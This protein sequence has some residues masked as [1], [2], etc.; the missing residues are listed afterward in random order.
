MQALSKIHYVEVIST[1]RNP[2][3]LIINLTLNKVAEF[4]LPPAI[5]LLCFV[6]IVCVKQIV[7]FVLWP[8]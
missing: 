7:V 6:T 2:A 1:N 4:C 3:S 5:I 8:L